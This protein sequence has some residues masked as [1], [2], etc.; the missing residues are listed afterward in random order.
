MTPQ[1]TYIMSHYTAVTEAKH[2]DVR[3]LQAEMTRSA[4]RGL[5]TAVVNLLPRAPFSGEVQSQRKA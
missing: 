2:R 5:I 4:L 1:E 3:L